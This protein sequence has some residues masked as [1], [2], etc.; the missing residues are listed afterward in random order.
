ME[1]ER[2]KNKFRILTLK[3]YREDNNISF[4]QNEMNEILKFLKIKNIDRILSHYYQK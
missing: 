3:I 1:E 4:T 2:K